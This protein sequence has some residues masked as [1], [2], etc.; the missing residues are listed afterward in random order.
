MILQWAVIRERHNQ[1]RER[2]EE[3]IKAKKGLD[4]Q[5]KGKD[6]EGDFSRRMEKEDQK[7]RKLLRVLMR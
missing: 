4:T 2:E 6:V 3:E 7:W 1:E 5:G